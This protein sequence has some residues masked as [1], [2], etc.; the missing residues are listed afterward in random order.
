MV[1]GNSCTC[2]NSVRGSVVKPNIYNLMHYSLVSKIIASISAW[3]IAAK[4]ETALTAI[5]IFEA[6][7]DNFDREN[8]LQ[9]CG[10]SLE[11]IT[12]HLMELSNANSRRG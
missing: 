11:Q 4:V 6:D 3:A 1:G 5:H 9:G 12:N 10:V 7:S 8:F 2:S